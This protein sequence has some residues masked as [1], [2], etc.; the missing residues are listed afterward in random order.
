MLGRDKLNHVGTIPQYRE[1]LGLKRIVENVSQP[2][3][4]DAMPEEHRIECRRLDLFQLQLQ[5]VMAKD[6]L[7][8]PLDHLCQGLIGRRVTSVEGKHHKDSSSILLVEIQHRAAP[9]C[10]LEG[11]VRLDLFHPCQIATIQ[12]LEQSR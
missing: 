4:Q 6:P 5:I 3:A 8:P 2:F 9:L 1:Y 7:A 12:G 11:D 10:R